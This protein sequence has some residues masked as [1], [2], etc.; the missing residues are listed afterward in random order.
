MGRTRR[1]PTFTEQL[2]LETAEELLAA[3]EHL[4]E[5]VGRAR[6]PAWARRHETLGYA[7]LSGILKDVRKG[8]ALLGTLD[9]APVRS[10]TGRGRAYAETAGDQPRGA[11]GRNQPGPGLPVRAAVR[12]LPLVALPP[13]PAG[14]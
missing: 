5:Q 13:G 12:D 7:V 3:L 4:A 2:A 10:A 14:G 9:P 6:H 1:E 11:L 8:A